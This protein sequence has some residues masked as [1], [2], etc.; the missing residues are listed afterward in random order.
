MFSSGS[1]T[2]TPTRSVRITPV[3]GNAPS[4]T[5]FFINSRPAGPFRTSMTW[6]ETSVPAIPA[7]TSIR[8][9]AENLGSLASTGTTQTGIAIANPNPTPVDVA[10]EL[11]GGDGIST[12]LE[13]TISI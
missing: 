8:V 7:S 10:L 13:D 9:F 1:F 4:V 3:T 12:G 5:A 2:S 11:F 6:T